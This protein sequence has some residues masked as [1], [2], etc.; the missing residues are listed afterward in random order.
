MTTDSLSKLVYSSLS[1]LTC[2]AVSVAGA[3]RSFSQLKLIKSFY[4]SN[5][6]D[7]RHYVISIISI[8]RACVRDLDFYHIVNMFADEKAGRKTF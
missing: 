3:E 8:E 7:K 6:M 4:R 1:L 5:V 2:P